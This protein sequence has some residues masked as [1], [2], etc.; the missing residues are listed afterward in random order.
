MLLQ[1]VSPTALPTTAA[2]VAAGQPLDGW[3]SG[4]AGSS[5][6]N[7]PPAAA[8]AGGPAALGRPLQMQP[9]P[10]SAS[11]NDPAA[12]AAA[13][14]GG[15]RVPSAE[16]IQ[17]AYDTAQGPPPK[18]TAAAGTGSSTPPPAAAAADNAP[19]AAA[20]RGAAENVSNGDGVVQDGELGLPGV[21]HAGDGVSANS[22]STLSEYDEL[23]KRFDA[24]KKS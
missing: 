11:H 23:Q 7:T 6:A 20:G 8:P 19:A 2:G 16:A 9:L 15:Y 10:G 22:S 13:K 12:A 1:V 5:G 21:P 17:R 4:V 24:L 18:P 3:L 14:P